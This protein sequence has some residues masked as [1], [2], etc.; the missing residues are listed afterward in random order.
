MSKYQQLSLVPPSCT[1]Q[2]KLLKLHC[3]HAGFIRAGALYEQT[4]KEHETRNT[5][6]VIGKNYRGWVA[7]ASTHLPFVPDWHLVKGVARLAAET[8]SEPQ[9]KN[10]LMEPEFYKPG[11]ILAIAK[12][13]DVFEMTLGNLPESELERETGVWEPGRWAIQL[14]EAIAPVEPIP[15]NIPGQGAVYLN[16][17][18]GDVYGE[19]IKL[20]NGRSTVYA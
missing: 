12:V 15:Y 10:R 5:S 6:G 3:T 16:E 7:I 9:W 18:H 1:L 13:A 2:I 4:L 14:E 20:I 17:G 11:C 8:Y 19:V